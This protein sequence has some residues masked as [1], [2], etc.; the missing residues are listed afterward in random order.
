LQTLGGV[1]QYLSLPPP[2]TA[3]PNRFISPNLM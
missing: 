3:F 2:R 1:K